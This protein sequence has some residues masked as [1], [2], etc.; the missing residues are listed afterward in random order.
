MLNSGKISV[1][2]KNVDGGWSQLA[3]DL[4]ATVRL[5]CPTK[6]IKNVNGDYLFEDLVTCKYSSPMVR[7]KM[8]EC[9]FAIEPFICRMNFAENTQELLELQKKCTESIFR[10]I[11]LRH[12]VH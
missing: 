2:V 7:L 8:A 3:V 9:L 4:N 12:L 11:D 6:F 5:N 10:L 1:D